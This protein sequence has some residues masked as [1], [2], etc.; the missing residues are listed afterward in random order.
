MKRTI[1][2]KLS[3]G[4]IEKTEIINRTIVTVLT[5]EEFESKIQSIT[6]AQQS[7]IVYLEKTNIIKDSMD[8]A[9]RA[10]VDE[11]IIIDTDDDGNIII[12]E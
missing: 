8:A 9:L 7:R 1:F 11:P 5:V 2:K 6:T 4:N 10:S 12:I 3:N